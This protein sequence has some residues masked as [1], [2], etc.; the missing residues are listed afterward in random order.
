MFHFIKQNHRASS[1]LLTLCRS[2]HR[3]HPGHK[4]RPLAVVP[5][6]ELPDKYLPEANYPPVKPKLPPGEWPADVIESLAWKQFEEGQKFHSL[7]T[8]QER[9]SVMAYMNIQQTLSDLKIR[10][11]RWNPIHVTSSVSKTARMLPFNQY[12]TK[13]D[14][15]KVDDLASIGQSKEARSG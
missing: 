13:T 5:R 9:M 8:I 6:H 11:T 14:V 2:V 3:N 1:L 7:K 10:G 15:E 4:K 12:I